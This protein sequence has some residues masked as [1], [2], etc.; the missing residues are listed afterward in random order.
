MKTGVSICLFAALGSMCFG[1]QIPA[2]PSSNAGNMTFYDAVAYQDGFLAVGSQGRVQRIST[3][4]QSTALSAGTDCDFQD[5]ASDGSYAV[6]V[7]TDGTAAMISGDG[8]V[9]VFSTGHDAALR[10]I[11]S[12]RGMWLAGAE[13]GMLLR[14]RD[15]RFW[16]PQQLSVQGTIT[17]LA[18][19]DERC[20]G[21]TDQG[22]ILVTTD[23]LRWTV[24]D[25][26]AYY[27]QSL[28]FQGIE[29]IDGTFW[30]YGVREDGTSEIIM[31]LEGGVWSRRD[32]IVIEQSREIDLS[33]TEI[34]GLCSDGE[35]TIAALADG[36][37]L[38]M[39]SCAECNKRSKVSENSLGAVAYNNGTLLFAGDDFEYCLKS[40]ESIRQERIRAQA[41][42]E[43]QQ[44][45]AWI[46]DV[47]SAE[48]FTQKHI[49]GSLHM[50]VDQISE[51][52][53]V[54]C[55][56]KTREIIF[57]CASGVRSQRALE[58][59]RSLGYQ[60]VYNLGGI[61]DWPYSLE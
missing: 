8:T 9:S 20:I 22:E 56:D 53:P 1:T 42:Y 48:E 26:N 5:I 31:S 57:Y 7:G 45:G 19:T 49:A 21:V 2:E 10:S 30:A 46:I 34:V 38:T 11:C 47:R 43:K 29:E 59:A 40:M 28:Y 12:F 23:G 13:N 55:P 54:V 37:A 6:T 41:A 35:Q 25:Y 61:A 33:G 32:L 58:T 24:L 15:F 4:G 60:Y 36:Q 39:P 27:G 44:A 14:T 17:G 3:D 50:D 18:C 51:Q 52:L 16:E